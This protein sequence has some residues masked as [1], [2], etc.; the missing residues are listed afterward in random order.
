MLLKITNLKS[1]KKPYVS[2]GKVVFYTLFVIFVTK[3]NH[4]QKN[5][6]IYS[7]LGALK[8]SCGNIGNKILESLGAVRLVLISKSNTALV[9]GVFQ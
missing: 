2:R 9:L 4:K 7:L 6:Y 3:Y 5:K 1:R 8:V